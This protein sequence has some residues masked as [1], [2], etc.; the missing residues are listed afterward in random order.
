MT[1]RNYIFLTK[2]NISYRCC[3]TIINGGNAKNLVSTQVIDKLRLKSR[4]QPNDYKVL[5]LQKG[6]H[7]K[8]THQYLI[9]FFNDPKIRKNLKIFK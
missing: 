1:Q 4:P 9:T 3:I 5:W 8:M 2:M 6:N 7:V